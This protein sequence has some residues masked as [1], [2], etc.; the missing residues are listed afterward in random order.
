MSVSTT[1]KTRRPSLGTAFSCCAR[2]ALEAA[3]YELVSASDAPK[4]APVLRGEVNACWWWSY[5]WFWPVVVQGG[6]N[7]VTLFLD[8]SNGE[9]LWKHEFSRIE[10]G[11]SAGTSY[12]FDLMIK[13]S[14]TKLVQDIVRECSTDGFKATLTTGLVRQG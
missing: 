3:G 13:W 14:M 1:N 9:N 12:G 6:E 7:K 10:P 8:S 11:I 2:S 5:S 4:D